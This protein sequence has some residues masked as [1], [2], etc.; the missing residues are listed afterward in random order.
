MS[1]Q[2]ITIEFKQKNAPELIKSVK[3]LDKATKKLANT[4]IKAGQEAKN[5][6]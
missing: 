5:G 2:N 1:V 3:D 6:N 4:H